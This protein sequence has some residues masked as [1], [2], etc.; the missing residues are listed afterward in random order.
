[1]NNSKQASARGS[2]AA[3]MRQKPSEAELRLI[4]PAPATRAR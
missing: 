3:M 4:L 1:M 2:V